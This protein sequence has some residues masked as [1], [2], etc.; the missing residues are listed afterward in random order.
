MAPIEVR[1][2]RRSRKGDKAFSA[3][4]NRKIFSAAASGVFGNQ[5]A[6]NRDEMGSWSPYF[7]G[8][9]PETDYLEN[10]PVNAAVTRSGPRFN[11]CIPK[12]F[13]PAPTIFRIRETRLLSLVVRQ[14][15]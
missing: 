10:N 11:A 15:I 4:T 3:P 8:T 13:E 5:A 14:P 1:Q 2:W 9:R 7:G 12:M 6:A